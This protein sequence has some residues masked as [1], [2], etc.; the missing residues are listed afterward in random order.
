MSQKI[1]MFSLFMIAVGSMVGSGWLFGSLYSAKIAGPAALVSWFLG[2]ACVCIIAIIYAEVSTMLPVAGG[3][4]TYMR[5]SH[6]QFAGFMFAWITWMW[7]M[8]VPPIE[9]SAAVQYASNYIPGLVQTMEGTHHL[10]GMG[11]AAAC[12]LLLLLT[13]INILGL[14][15]L[16]KSNNI[17]T[18]FKLIIPIGVAILLIVKSDFNFS[19][20]TA[21]KTG[22]FMPYGLDSVVS[23]LSGGAIAFSFFGF[24]AIIFLGKEAHNPQ[25]SIPL[26]LFGGLAFCTV[27]YILL[28]AGFIMSIPESA[29]V[30]GWKNLSFAGD[31]GPFAGILAGLGFAWMVYILNTDAVLSPTGTANG[32]VAAASRI[33][34]SMGLQKDAPQWLVKLNRSHIPQVAILFNFCIGMLFFLPFGGWQSMVAFLSSAIV[35]TLAS[36]PLCLPIF[37]KFHPDLYRPFKVPM[38][39]ISCFVAFYVCNLLLFWAGWKTLSKLYIVIAAGIVIYTLS[40]MLK[41]MPRPNSLDLKS[42]LWFPAYLLF[43][44]LLSYYGPFGGGLGVFDV[45]AGFAYVACSSIVIYVWA[46]CSALSIERG[47]SE[48]AM[49]NAKQPLL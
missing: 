48:L 1:S 22:G 40:Y 5:L 47:Q 34:Y 3:S 49:I 33:L 6:G 31:A 45:F 25:R 2:A 19:H 44:G 35:L 27:M 29:L 30:N 21:E 46:Q 41:W 17:I 4:V 13:V 42:C 26:A 10:T 18:F 12:T 14:K 43:S 36:A 23:A 16:T 9:A 38:L 32:Y 15:W 20:F 8:I 24:Q 7:T 11:I 39:H 37:R 28:Q